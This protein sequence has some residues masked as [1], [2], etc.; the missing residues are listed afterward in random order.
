MNK[1]KDNLKYLPYV[2]QTSNFRLREALTLLEETHRKLTTTPNAK[3]SNDDKHEL[4]KFRNLLNKVSSD[5]SEIID[6]PSIKKPPEQM[7]SWEGAKLP[8]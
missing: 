4:Y 6:E 7:F 8:E 5:I 1:N 3:L 2:L